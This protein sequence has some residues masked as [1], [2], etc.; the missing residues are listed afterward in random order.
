MLKAIKSRVDFEKRIALTVKKI[1]KQVLD[2]GEWGHDD[3]SLKVENLL[4][5][6]IKPEPIKPGQLE[7]EL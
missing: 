4:K 1:P 6:A 7:L 2:R 3:Y 5:A